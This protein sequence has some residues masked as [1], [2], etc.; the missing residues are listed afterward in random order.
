[1][2]PRFYPSCKT[3]HQPQLTLAGAQFLQ[4]GCSLQIF[5]MH[6]A[7]C[8]TVTKFIVWLAQ[9]GSTA[10]CAQSS[11]PQPLDLARPRSA[12]PEAIAHCSRVSPDPLSF[13]LQFRDFFTV[14]IA[15]RLAKASEH[16]PKKRSHF[17]HKRRFFARPFFFLPAST[18]FFSTVAE[19]ALLG[20]LILTNRAEI[21][22]LN[23]SRDQSRTVRMYNSPG[24]CRDKGQ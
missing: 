7:S 9:L 12:R 5:A 10:E 19:Q 20:I 21:Q 24:E 14:H 18:F 4:G 23:H 6:P 8:H 15:A 2:L 1:V 16:I 3:P 11:V 13:S 22:P 17:R